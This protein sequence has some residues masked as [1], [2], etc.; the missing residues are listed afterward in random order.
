MRG[1]IRLLHHCLFFFLFLVSLSGYAQ[2][3]SV[4]KGKRVSPL[5]KRALAI[6]KT[7]EAEGRTVDKLTAQ[8]FTR[9]PVGLV[10]EIGGKKYVIAIDSAYQNDQGWFF[11]AYAVLTIPGTTEPL[12]FA[13]RGLAFNAGGLAATNSAKLVL[14]SEHSVEMGHVTLELPG[15]GH[16][17]V[18][19]DCNG[20]KAVNMKGIFSFDKGLLLPDDSLQRQVS[21][22]FE[23]HAADLNN[24]MVSTSVSPFQVKG[25]KGFSF[26]VKNAVL[27]LSD[28]ANPG[29]FSFPR[30]YQQ[31]YG[32]DISLWRGFYLQEAEVKLPRELADKGSR[33]SILAALS[34]C[35]GF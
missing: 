17:Y 35:S 1:C 28:F 27:D 19:F 14:M 34:P 7:V 5:Y 25:L 20:F 2:E 22:T 3:A 15:D 16:N 13:G 8:D 21:A 29:G 26:T 11:T 18:E 23:V 10:K 32:D 33:T 24:I 31:T 9:L 30:D 4:I 12:A 6:I